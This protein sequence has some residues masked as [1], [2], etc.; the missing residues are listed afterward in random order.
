MSENEAT[1]KYEVPAALR[2]YHM[3]GDFCACNDPA[4]ALVMAV[5]VRDATRR[6]QVSANVTLMEK[7]ALLDLAAREA[8]K[9]GADMAA[10]DAWFREMIREAAK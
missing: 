5:R 4:D 8:E 10:A 9:A 7:R 2:G 1:Y 6:A 3:S